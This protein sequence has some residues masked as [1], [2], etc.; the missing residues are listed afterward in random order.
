MGSSSKQNNPGFTANGELRQF[1]RHSYQDHAMENDIPKTSKEEDMLHRYNEN[2]VGGPFPLKLHI[3]L[4]IL[5]EEGN[6]CIISWLPHGRA[7]VI[8][9]PSRFEQEVVKRFFKHSQISSFR[10]QLNL[11]GFLRLSNGRDTG[12]YYH[13]LFLRGKPILSLRMIRTKVKGTKIRASSSPA[14]EPRFYVMP[15]LGPIRVQETCTSASRC[16]PASMMD[17]VTSRSN[18]AM[19]M[20]RAQ[21]NASQ[22][23]LS[24]AVSVGANPAASFPPTTRS[25]NMRGQ[26]HTQCP[27]S[28][29]NM[30]HQRNNLMNMNGM[31]NKSLATMGFGGA[32]CSR[33]QELFDRTLEQGRRD[34]MNANLRNAMS[35]G[36]DGYMNSMGMPSFPMSEGSMNSCH[37]LPSSLPPSGRSMLDETTDPRALAHKMARAH[38]FSQFENMMNQTSNI[39]PSMSRMERSHL[40][41]KQ[42]HAQRK[43]FLL[44]NGFRPQ[45]PLEFNE[46]HA[47]E[48]NPMMMNSRVVSGFPPSKLGSIRK[49]QS[50]LNEGIDAAAAMVSLGK[51]NRSASSDNSVG[52]CSTEEEKDVASTMMALGGKSKGKYGASS[53]RSPSEIASNS[54]D[55]EVASINH[56]V[57]QA[58]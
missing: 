23:Y 48:R 18:A 6:D 57:Q 15:F 52:A 53:P 37:R 10:R 41:L 30:L 39:L 29:I 43:E 42:A 3:I 12:A 1:V 4:K 16:N 8:H 25:M 49:Q 33:A 28:D 51:K 26:L 20:R 14:D 45:G 55:S 17:P 58:V 35:Y 11:Y 36:T 56:T 24:E 50:I 32:S 9:N 47:P 5:E 7:F 22:D 54:V 38:Y 13:Q 34:L 46:I 44:R 40:S 31:P 2:R 19:M 21:G 27:P